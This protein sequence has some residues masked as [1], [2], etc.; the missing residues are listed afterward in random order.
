MTVSKP[1]TSWDDVATTPFSRVVPNKVKKVK[2]NWDVA[3]TNVA[4][5]KVKKVKQKKKTSVD[6]IIMLIIVLVLHDSV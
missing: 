5:E 6:H 2:Q 4:P 3:T 1:D